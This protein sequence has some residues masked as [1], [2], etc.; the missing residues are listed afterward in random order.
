MGL[1]LPLPQHSA[2][3]HRSSQVNFPRYFSYEHTGVTILRPYHDAV[4][5]AGNSRGGAFTR[6]GGGESPDDAEQPR[7][8]LQTACSFVLWLHETPADLSLSADAAQRILKSAGTT[9]RPPRHIHASR[10]TAPALWSG[11]ACRRQAGRYSFDFLS[12]DAATTTCTNGL[13]A[14]LTAALWNRPHRHRPGSAAN[15]GDAI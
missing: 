12:A 9:G 7:A 6:H 10:F 3:A 14:L 2:S 8:G 13:S 4:A 11:V 15:K 1:V 5:L